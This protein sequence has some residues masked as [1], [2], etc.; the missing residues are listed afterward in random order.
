MC[1][2]GVDPEQ[3]PLKRHHH[4]V[5]CSQRL[6]LIQT[7]H[8]VYCQNSLRI[9]CL[10]HRATYPSQGYPCLCFRDLYKS[11]NSS[12]ILPQFLIL[13]SVSILL[14]I[15]VSNIFLKIKDY[16]SQMYTVTVHEYT[17]IINVIMIVYLFIYYL[18]I[19]GSTALC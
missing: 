6:I 11:R 16:V 4:S 14:S 18:S 9:S 3:D 2:V 1:E 10:P 5:D 7:L 8:F 15:L 17:Q 13:S 19:Y 12:Y